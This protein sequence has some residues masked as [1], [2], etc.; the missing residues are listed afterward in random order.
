MIVAIQSEVCC[1]LLA[2][3]ATAHP[4]IKKPVKTDTFA[5][6]VLIVKRKCLTCKAGVPLTDG[7]K[8]GQT[9]LDVFVFCLRSIY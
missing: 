3:H 5:W 8:L 6:R 1:G 9:I 2:Y 4:A 7:I